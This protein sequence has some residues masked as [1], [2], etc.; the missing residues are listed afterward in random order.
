MT[1]RALLL[2]AALALALAGCPKR[3]VTTVGGGDDQ[4]MDA[5]SSKLEELRSRTDLPCQESC[6]LKP[7][8]CGLSS[9]ACGISARF[10]A[11]ADFERTCV[12]AQEECARF[13]EAC[14]RC[15]K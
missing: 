9:E 8:A 11:R 4:R 10:P 14:E 13:N 15:V 7:R 6:G 2:A 12:Q 3:V 1:T 5:L